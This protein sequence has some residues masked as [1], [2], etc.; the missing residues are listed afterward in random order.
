MPRRLLALLFC[1]LFSTA[2]FA[3]TPRPVG[4]VL[5][6]NPMFHGVANTMM[7]TV[8]VTVDGTGSDADHVAA[9]GYV[10][11]ADYGSCT[12]TT[13]PW[14]W[15]A[16]QTYDTSATRT[17]TL[18]NF[19]PGRSYYYKWMVGTPGGTVRTRCAALRTSTMATPSLPAN[20]ADL[21]LRYQKTG[22]YET[23]YVLFETEDCGAGGMSDPS[24]YYLVVVDADE[25]SIVWYLD[26]GANTGL[27]GI[28]S[29]LH[30]EE[31]LT[32]D[33][34]RMHLT[35]GNEAIYEWGFD[36]VAKG[37]YDFGADDECDGQTGSLGPCVHHDIVRS[38]DT[39][40]TYAIAAKV[41]PVT[42]I[43]TDWDARC[44]ATSQFLDE[45]YL[46]LDPDFSLVDENFLIEDQGFDPAVDGGPDASMY[47]MASGSCD[48]RHWA[49]TYDPAIGIIDWGH[50]NAMS[51]S[52]YDG[53]EVIDLSY[54]N[55]DR[56]LRFD[57]ATGDLLWSLSPNSGYSDWGRVRID[58]GVSGAADFD[59]QHDVN[60]IGSNQFMMID[61]RGETTG[62]RVL[63]IELTDTPTPTT[64]IRK[65]WAITDSAG[66]PIRCPIEGTGRQVPGST[67]DHV[68]SMCA[69]SYA[70]MELDDPTGASG[71][72]PLLYISLPSTNY[73]A[74][75]GPA[76]RADIQGWHKG[77]PLERVGAF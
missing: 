55:W 14:K 66:A 43:G 26:V 9:V 49:G 68:L 54:K 67:D 6:R 72:S 75:G 48:S 36:E 29:G 52:S 37:I 50:Q 41:S 53:Y 70:V 59:S 16:S 64:W 10:E 11:A 45:G 69:D 7:Y 27:P 15:A 71:T 31:G 47:A 24:S 76:S 4:R 56:I 3:A 34:D 12:D 62:S 57:A 13:T 40:N 8:A 61:N 39:G 73:C 46:V 32:P 20:L 17:W 1:A 18:Y 25:E 60:A 5:V 77:Y 33:D 51:V 42:A 63:E 2:A 19:V 22:P 44:D 30:Y 74:G 28:A 58:S 38:N 23:K 35:V 65:S 21:N